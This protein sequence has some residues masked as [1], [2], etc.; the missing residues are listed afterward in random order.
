MDNSPTPRTLTQ[1]DHEKRWVATTS[2]AAAFLLTGTKLGIGIWTNSLGILSEAAHSALDLAAAGVTLFAVRVSGRPADQDH[3]YGHGKIENLSALFEAVLLLVTCVWIIY[4]AIQRLFFRSVEIEASLW[5]FLIMGISIVV[6]YSRSR[7]LYHAARK[8]DSQALEADALH[9]STDIWSSSVVIVGLFLVRLAGVLHVDWLVK[10]DAV[11]AL[12][13]AGIVTYVSI[14]LGQ[15]T[16]AGLLDAAPAGLREK[17]IQ[18]VRVPG[19]L[20]VRQARLRRSGPETFADVILTVAPDTTL[21]R[22]HDIASEAEAAVRVLAPSSDVVVHVEP[23]GS[24]EN[25]VVATVRNLASR[26]GLSAHGLG[27]FNVD[28]SRSLEL[29]LE[30]NDG[31]SVDEAHR[32]VSAFEADLKRSLPAIGEIVTHIEPTGDDSLTRQGTVVDELQVAEVLRYLSLQPGLECQFHG[33]EVRRVANELNVTFHCA[34]DPRTAIGDAHARTVAVEQA[35]RA[36]LPNLGRV[37][38]H[39]EPPETAQ[40]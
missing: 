17:L 32:Q 16:I 5:A 13:V 19:V 29:H 15:R 9:F 1:A 31:L 21:E 30:V 36:R 23:V 28:G 39:V 11:A 20:D 3:T 34:V 14:Q 38:I 35:L 22:A 25:G 12:G 37:V 27:V 18:A 40:S 2:L 33:L 7:A 26:H 4:E 8:Y 6:D 24:E 10:A